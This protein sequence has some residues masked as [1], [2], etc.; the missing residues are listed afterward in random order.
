[1]IVREWPQHHSKIKLLKQ[2]ARIREDARRAEPLSYLYSYGTRPLDIDR[3]EDPTAVAPQQR[4]LQWDEVEQSLRVIL[5][6]LAQAH[7]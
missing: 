6:W 4:R 3:L 7:R 5:P 2:A 1:M